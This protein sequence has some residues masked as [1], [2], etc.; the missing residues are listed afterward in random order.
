MTGWGQSMRIYRFDHT[1]AKNIKV[2]G[3][4]K[5]ALTRIVDEIPNAFIG[6]LYIEPDG[7]LVY[8]QAVNDQLYLVVQGSGWVSGQERERKR[9][10]AG[11]AAFW[12][13]GEYHESGSEEG[14]TVVIVEAKTIDHVLMEKMGHIE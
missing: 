4:R 12:R 13:D 8:H 11:Q 9:I 2:D 1:T 10:E 7:I 3:C 14:M 6:V 5:V